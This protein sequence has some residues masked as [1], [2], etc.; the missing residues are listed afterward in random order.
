[1]IDDGYTWWWGEGSTPE[2]Y[3]PANSREEAIYLAAESAD[4]TGVYRVTICEGKP[5]DLRDNFFYAERVLDDW[6]D[7]NSDAADED[8]ELQM[9][10][11]NEQRRELEDALNAAFAAWRAKHNLGRAYALHTRNEEVIDLPEAEGETT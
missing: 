8:G 2:C 10:P 11:T 9:E 7:F 4:D 3:H 5:W 1:M 6:H